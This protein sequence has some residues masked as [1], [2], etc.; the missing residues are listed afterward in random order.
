M[1]V[2]QTDLYRVSVKAYN[3]KYRRKWL[4]TNMSYIFSY[5]NDIKLANIGNA[6][7]A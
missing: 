4:I 6:R 5:S 2:V 1:A 7:S 3:K